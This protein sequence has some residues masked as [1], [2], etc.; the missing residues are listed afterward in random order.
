MIYYLT[1]CS[2]PAKF[3]CKCCD[4]LNLPVDIANF[5]NHSA[6]TASA[7]NDNDNDDDALL[8]DD[9]L[10]LEND[11]NTATEQWAQGIFTYLHSCYFISVYLLALVPVHC[12]SLCYF[13]Y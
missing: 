7:A 10:I 12:S 11:C 2:C 9:L 4:K 5:F 8:D 1:D 6:A 3:L 13:N